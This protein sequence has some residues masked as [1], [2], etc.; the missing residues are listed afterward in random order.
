MAPAEAFRVIDGE[1][2]A[3]SELLAQ[4]ERIVAAS[5]CEGAEDEARAAELERAIGQRVWRV[6]AMQHRGLQ[7]ILRECHTRVHAAAAARA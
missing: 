4:K 7:E 1:V 5:K 6:S 2:R 3:F